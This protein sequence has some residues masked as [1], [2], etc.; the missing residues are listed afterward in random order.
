MTLVNSFR[1]KDKIVDLEMSSFAIAKLLIYT[2]S[3]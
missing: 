2:P 3:L 1:Y